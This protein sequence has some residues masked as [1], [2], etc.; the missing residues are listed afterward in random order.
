MS[1]CILPA[2]RTDSSSSFNA[3]KIRINCIHIINTILNIYVYIFNIK[4]KN[5]RKKERGANSQ[6]VWKARELL[7]S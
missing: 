1:V 6:V 2:F 3:E 7:R 4:A 5:C